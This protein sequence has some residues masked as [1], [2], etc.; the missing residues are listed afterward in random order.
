MSFRPLA[1]RSAIVRAAASLGI[2]AVLASCA[3]G[4]STP[5]RPT[6][7]SLPAGSPLASRTLSDGDAWLRHYLMTG[8][9][10]AALQ[11]IA[12]SKALPGDKLLRQLQA[13]VVLH[14]AGRFEESNRAFEWAEQEADRRYTKSVARAAGSIL[15]ND[16]VLAYAP[17]RAELAAIPYY[18]MLNYV[19]LGDMA[20]AAVEA[21]KASALMARLG[22]S[23][24]KGC[25]GNGFVQYLGGLVYG[26]ARETNDALVSFR[27][28]ERSFRS[29]AER[30]GIS[31]PAPLTLDLLH[32]ARALGME[33]LV[34]S[35]AAQFSALESVGPEM[36]AGDLVV[37]VEHGF[38]A[39]LAEEDVHIPIFEED[40]L[41]L[42]HDTGDGVSVIADRITTRL[43]GSADAHP[44]GGFVLADMPLAH[45][46]RGAEV[47]HVLKLAWPV[48]RREPS[49]AAAVRVL[50]DS[51]TLDPSPV[52]DLSTQLARDLEAERVLLASR[53][54]ARGLV[55]Y[56][57]SAEA[58]KKAEK[59]GGEAAAFLVGLLTNTAA[60][61]LERA[62][63]R[64]WSLL[65][66]QVS[67]AKVRLPAGEHHVRL[68]VLAGDNAS[69][70]VLDL[71]QVQI[72]PGE[73]VFLSRRVWGADDGMARRLSGVARGR[74]IDENDAVLPDTIS[75]N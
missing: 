27:Q 45:W 33:D 22:G 25:I 61:V 18:R 24:G 48:S 43:F 15:V 2:A 1:P 8:E 57:L 72:R 14:Q 53:M 38:V 59:Q 54:V 56:V 46:D 12:R 74:G 28:A 68:E 62:D 23:E 71:G 52:Y 41:G 4:L 37:L 29:C 50:V 67:L 69:T 3:P 11:L 42:G 10:D 30:D 73:R 36:A 35:T 49:R 34:D 40:T 9:Y 70:Y 32:T 26:A 20:G 51:S 21:R 16:R 66:D 63:T 44:S 47:A 64:S 75:H 65:P 6:P 31:P 58:E 17:S 55:K 19:A 7:S 5:P 60:N 39:H 13:G